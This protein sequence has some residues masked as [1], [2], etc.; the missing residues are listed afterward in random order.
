LFFRDQGTWSPSHRVTKSPSHQVTWSPSH[1]VTRG[2]KITNC[3]VFRREVTHNDRSPTTNNHFQFSII[4]FQF[5]CILNQASEEVVYSYRNASGKQKILIT[6]DYLGSW[7]AVTD[8]TGR[9]VTYQGAEQRYSFDPWGRRRNALSW[10]YDDTPTSFLFDRGYTGHEHLDAF[11]LI[12][13]NGRVYDPVIA[14]FLSPDPVLQSPSNGQNY[15]RYSYC[16]NNPLKYVDPSGYSYGAVRPE[17]YFEWMNGYYKYSGGGFFWR[18]SYR[19]YNVETNS[20]YSSTDR[21]SIQASTGYRYNFV[22]GKYYDSFNHT[23]SWFEVDLNEVRFNTQPISNPFVRINSIVRPNNRLPKRPIVISNFNWNIGYGKSFNLS[24]DELVNQY[25]KR[26][27]AY[28]F[29]EKEWAPIEGAGINA[30]F[31]IKG[32]INIGFDSWNQAWTMTVSAVG[33]TP[34]S[35]LGEIQ[36]SGSASV[37]VDGNI[38][39]TKNFQLDNSLGFY[40]RGTYP[41]GYVTFSLPSNGSIGLTINAGYTITVPEGKFSFRSNNWIHIFP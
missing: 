23:V 7:Y 3:P 2:V 5:S 15:N 11:G 24:Y 17:N 41:M 30:S 39:S 14:R 9:I 26:S 10:E 32:N 38:T 25:F 22:N 8:A 20:F 12:N 36:F 1:L 28:S 4:N 40:E 31:T 34:I 21:S 18:G 33:I 19:Q 6:K 13:M 37:E 35:A 29:F 16:L 27:F